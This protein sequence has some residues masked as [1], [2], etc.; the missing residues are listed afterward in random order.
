MLKARASVA[1]IAGVLGAT[2][3]MAQSTQQPPAATPPKAPVEGQLTTQPADT[4]LTRDIVGQNVYQP[5]DTKIG[6]I[7]DLLLSKDGRDVQGFVVGV[8][9]FLGIG[10]RS[11]ALKLDKLKV[12]PQAEGKVKLVMDVKREE[13]AN[14]PPFKSRREIESEKRAAERPSPPVRS[15][16]RDN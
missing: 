10:E 4:L 2:A 5:D 11:V 16:Q 15:T 12:M 1:V 7:S 6:S 13:L 3:A 14:A 8:G 9:G